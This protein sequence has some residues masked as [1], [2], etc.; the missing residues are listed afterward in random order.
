MRKQEEKNFEKDIVDKCKTQPKLFYRFI[1]RKIKSKEKVER[2][3]GEEGII[4]DPKGMAELLNNRFQQVFTKESA[5]EKP[6]VSEE[7]VHMKEI[8]VTKQEIH[9]LL[10]ELEEEKAMG[11]DE[12][13]G[14]ILKA[15]REELTGPIHDIIECSIESGEVP[16]EWKRAEVVPIYKSGGKEEPLNYRPVSL[17]S[18]VSKICE[19]VIKKHWT[20]FLEDHK[21]ISDSQFGF[22]KGRSCVTNLLSFYSRV[23]DILQERDG[24]VDCVYLDLKK[25]FDNVPHERLLWKLEHKGGLKGKVLKWM[26]SY[27]NGREMRTVIKDVKS[28]WRAVE[29]GVP[30]GSVLA[31]ILFLIY[32]ND[33]PEGV[34]SYIN[35]FADDAKLCRQVKN[36][37]DCNILQEDLNKIWRWSNKWE[38]KFNVD[39][40][41]VMEMGK[42][43]KRPDGTY[44][45]GDGAILKKVSKE[46]DLGVT[47]LD[48]NQPESHVNKIFGETYNLIR[49]IRL[50]F[51]YMDKEMMK[52]LI[53]TMIRPKLEYAGV[54]WSPH[55]KK[56]IKKLERIQRIATKMVPELAGLTYEERLRVMNLPT[57]E[58]RRERGDLIQVYKLMNGMDEVDNEKLIPRQAVTGRST[59]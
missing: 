26:E 35:L 38:M 42:S 16:V 32:I 57:L 22:R 1:N 3:R 40:S 55:K 11:P 44:K 59:R 5:F 24:W 31:P 10:E 23:V 51:H 13:S 14:N 34:K 50:A 52:K 47:I 4:D 54:V 2:L 36:K 43:G 45:L 41:H 17:T 53:T 29:S 58:Q 46:K 48:N 25:A 12:V 30:Q 56:H 18:V 27:L 6:Q 9:N 37:E 8:K 7:G 19:K 33:M 20:K 49:N 21:L 28:E 39:K 15:C